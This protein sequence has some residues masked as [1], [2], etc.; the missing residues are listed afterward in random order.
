[1]D[2]D[3]FSH[4][5]LC[6][7]IA[8]DKMLA[9]HTVTVAQRFGMASAK[10]AGKGVSSFAPLEILSA[11]ITTLFVAAPT[12]DEHWWILSIIF[13]VSWS[14]EDG[15][16]MRFDGHLGNDRSLQLQGVGG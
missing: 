14:Q 10:S 1:M 8:Q 12:C 11:S 4:I 3:N 2:K 15:G 13:V 6:C 9:E 7:T 16:V 5:Y